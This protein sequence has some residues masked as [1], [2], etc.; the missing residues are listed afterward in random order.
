MNDNNVI[1]IAPRIHKRRLEEAKSEAMISVNM[2]TARL[3]DIYNMVW[4]IPEHIEWDQAQDF[5]RNKLLF[6]KLSLSYEAMCLDMIGT[7]ESLHTALVESESPSVAQN[8]MLL[9]GTSELR[10]KQND[11]RL[12]SL[13][14]SLYDMATSQ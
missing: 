3:N 2:F 4:S 11:E 5:T 10:A 6:D 8:V 14:Y 9:I 7:F 12:S 1:D 13:Y